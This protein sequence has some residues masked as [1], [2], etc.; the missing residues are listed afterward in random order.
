MSVMSEELVVDESRFTQL[1]TIEVQYDSLRITN[2]SEI[3]VDGE[4]LI[5]H[6]KKMSGINHVKKLIIDYNS[7]L[8]NLH[9]ISVFTNLK[10]LYVYGKHIQTFEGIE[11]FTKGEFIRIDTRPNRRKDISQLSN[12]KVTGIDLFVERKEDLSAIAG[13][14]Y[15]KTIDICGSMEPDFKE[16]KDVQFE[17]LSF[18]GC[19][20]KE[21]GNTTEAFGL[22][23]MSVIGCRSLERF[24]GDNSR[25]TRMIIEGSK[26]LDLRTLG[27][28]SNIEALIVNGNSNE[29]ALSEIGQL[30]KLESLWL[31]NCKIHVDIHNLKEQFPNL[32]ELMIDSLTKEEV[33][34]LG[35]YNPDV[36]VTGKRRLGRG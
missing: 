8:I 21:L 9:V 32:E 17:S 33:L 10:I 28:F 12:T 20:F 24:T 11:S 29:V 35:E 30:T 36:E 7:S 2:P 16:W 27:T 31:L 6:L 25:I 15:L 26:K 5:E 23:N 3:Q 14:K 34:E 4:V 19:K 18:K 22:D 13:F 1:A